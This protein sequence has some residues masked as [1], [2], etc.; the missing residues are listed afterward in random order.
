MRC[1][2]CHAHTV[3][4]TRVG[5]PAA[6]PAALQVDVKDTVGCGDSFAA[7][8]ALGFTRGHSAEATL[9]LANAVGA[10][11]ATGRGAPCSLA[12]MLRT[13]CWNSC[14]RHPPPGL[15]RLLAC[16]QQQ[17]CASGYKVVWSSYIPL[18]SIRTG[19]GRS[20]AR[21]EMVLSL[22]EAQAAGQA[23]IAGSASPTAA[24]GAAMHSPTEALASANG[25][26]AARQAGVDGSAPVASRAAAVP[27]D[28]VRWPSLHPNPAAAA[29][30]LLK[31][32]LEAAAGSGI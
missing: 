4:P 26:G 17:P 23:E 14:L 20:V 18:L 30:E 24:E 9:A 27:G 11:T 2:A 8:V 6:A 32:S 25:A 22:L 7:A 19:A 12:G 16:G 28:D 15:T 10:A 29:V 5:F 1:G 13:A 21:A 31:Q 3:L